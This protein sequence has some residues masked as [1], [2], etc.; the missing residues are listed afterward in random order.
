MPA[1]SIAVKQK[2]GSPFIQRS[3]LL[4]GR[5][6]SGMRPNPRE[7]SG[8]QRDDLRGQRQPVDSR[9]RNELLLV[10]AQGESAVPAMYDEQV[11]AHRD[12]EAADGVLVESAEQES[13]GC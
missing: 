3:D 10:R 5:C 12:R 13:G 8:G 11:A 4:R 2:Q 1:P 7:F 6:R 9:R